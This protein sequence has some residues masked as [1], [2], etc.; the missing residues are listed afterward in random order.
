MDDKLLNF[1][2]AFTGNTGTFQMT[3]ECGKEYY[4]PDYS[5]DITEKEI[6]ELED[7]GA[8]AVDFTVGSICFGNNVYSDACDCWHGTAYR[9]INWMDVY[10]K[11]IAEY[12]KLEKMSKKRAYENSPIIE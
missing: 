9:I 7:R 2:K 12:F 1:S 6:K 10:G 5:W 4:N 3:C 8:H 11:Q